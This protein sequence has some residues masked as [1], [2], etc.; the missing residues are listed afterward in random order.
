MNKALVGLVVLPLLAGAAHATVY[1][2]SADFSLASNPN[3][4][5]TY[6]DETTLGATLNNYDKTF[7]HSGIVEWNSLAFDQAPLVANNPTNA[8]IQVGTVIVPAHSA[9]FHPGENGEFSV[10]RFTTLAAGTYAL[11]ASFY[12]ND[13]FPGGTDV[14][15]LDNGV[16]LFAGVVDGSHSPTYSNTL[17][18]AAG[19][20]IDF[21]VGF[22]LDGD[23][24]LDSTGIIATLTTGVNPVPEPATLGIFAIS[25]AALGFVRRRRPAI[26]CGGSTFSRSN[27]SRSQ[28]APWFFTHFGISK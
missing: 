11:A 8:P 14:H 12:P 13:I 20:I 21:A 16:S 22:G 19:D 17:A 25:L 28:T 15:I 23:W 7:I 2:A 3:G 6:G 1:N 18:L 10:F 5:W 26:S 4:V 9:D 27:R 24:S